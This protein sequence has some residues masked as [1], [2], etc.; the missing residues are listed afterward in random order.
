[1]FI[2]LIEIIIAIR[3][4]CSPVISLFLESC[5]YEQDT[6]YC[7]N[8][9]INKPLENVASNEACQLLCQK[10]DQ[11]NFWTFA[12]DGRKKCW[13]KSS[14]A[15]RRSLRGLASGPKFCSKLNFQVLNLSLKVT[16]LTCPSHKLKLSLL[17]TLLSNLSHI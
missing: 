2:Y 17:K 8:D 13:L 11:C 9:V 5:A 14:D 6:E 15:G 3:A 4:G 7:G 10:N 12:A 16:S 1:M